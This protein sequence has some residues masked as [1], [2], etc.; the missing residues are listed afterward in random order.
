MIL[1]SVVTT[2][3]T[4]TALASDTTSDKSKDSGDDDD[5][6][7]DDETKVSMKKN[8]PIHNVGEATNYQ[9]L[10]TGRF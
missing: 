7:N 10:H 1:Q 9:L 3:G 6:D 8:I 2:D 4:N 5:D